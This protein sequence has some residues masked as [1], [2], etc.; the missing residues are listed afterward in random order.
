MGISTISGVVRQVS[1]AIWNILHN[2]CIPKPT[3]ETWKLV[4]E[5]FEKRA[6]FPHCIGAIDGK[7]IRIIKPAH[8]GSMYFN[9]KQYFSIVL[10]AV[11]DSD[12]KFTYVDIGA[13]G[14]DCDSTVF[15]NTTFWKLLKENALAIPPPEPLE[16]FESAV[17]Y[18]IVGDEAFA[19]DDNLLRPFGGHSL[20][21]KKQIFNYRL[22]RARRYVECAFG[23]L[24]N[25]WRIFH[26]PFNVSTD[27][28][29][30]IV[31]AC[32]ILHNY[33]RDR[34]GYK[35]EDTMTI[36]EGIEDVPHGCSVRGGLSANEHRNLFADYFLS[37]K[38][39]V[40][41]QHLKI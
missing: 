32:C 16:A 41:W 30:D 27:F 20:C 29:V 3:T 2:D 12:Y 34:D 17:P 36:G 37:D 28:A 7:H 19:L 23:I 13:Y 5:K 26:R 24:S 25:K 4:A 33:V 35:P 14:K 10:L 40:P 9:Y 15:K 8:T 18:V 31:K 6:N 11:V 1:V 22:T 38:G 21:Y 39:A